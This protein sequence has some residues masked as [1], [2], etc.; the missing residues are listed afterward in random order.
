MTVKEE[1]KQLPQMKISGNGIRFHR[2]RN[3]IIAVTIVHFPKEVK[4]PG[5]VTALS[6][7][8]TRC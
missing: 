4:C 5:M 1:A 7:L 8:Y 2:F 6:I 3:F